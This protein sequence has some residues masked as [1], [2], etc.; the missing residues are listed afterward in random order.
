MHNYCK[1]DRLS[2]KKNKHQNTK[3]NL[4]NA[5][6][7]LS[8]CG[9]KQWQKELSENKKE[10]NLYYEE[11]LNT[12]EINAGNISLPKIAMMHKILSRKKN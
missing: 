12:F 5:K 8:F 7:D 6:A 10:P 3:D 1:T 9:K 2:R 4:F 11:K